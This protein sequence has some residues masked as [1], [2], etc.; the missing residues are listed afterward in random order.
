VCQDPEPGRSVWLSHSYSDIQAPL[1]VNGKR[2]SEVAEGFAL[3]LKNVPRIRCASL[4]RVVSSP[5]QASAA[6]G[7]RYDLVMHA[8][9]IPNRRYAKRSSSTH[10]NDCRNFYLGYDHADQPSALS[11]VSEATRAPWHPNRQSDLVCPM[12]K[13]QA[14]RAAWAFGLAVRPARLAVVSL[15]R[16]YH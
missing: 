1:A 3:R 9:K 14:V 13:A 2:S 4:W 16:L 11:W 8:T 7:V 5:N 6:C 15:R 10:G 12:D